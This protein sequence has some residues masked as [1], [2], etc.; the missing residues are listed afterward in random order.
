MRVKLTTLSKDNRP[1]DYNNDLIF[2]TIMVLCSYNALLH[3]FLLKTEFSAVSRSLCLRINMYIFAWPLNFFSAVF[4]WFINILY[5]LSRLTIFSPFLFHQVC[6]RRTLAWSGTG[7]RCSDCSV[8][9]RCAC[10]TTDSSTTRTRSTSTLCWLRWPV[11]TL[12]RWV[13]WSVV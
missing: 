6:C 11:N 2:W 3:W 8:T 5:V 4:Q 9:S 7:N 1:V 10:S 13:S 12:G